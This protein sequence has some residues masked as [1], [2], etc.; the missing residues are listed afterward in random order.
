MEIREMPVAVEKRSRA[1]GV[2]P[3]R[4]RLDAGAWIEAAFEALARDGVEA[5]R[6]EP[7]A[8]VLGVTKGSFYWHFADRD[9]LIGALFE[10]W[11]EGR[12]AA[13][14]AETADGTDA[15]ATLYRL[16]DLYARGPNARGLAIELAIRG[17]ARG[18]ARAAAAVNAVDAE[19]L[20]RVA[21]LFNAL[22]SKPAEA[23]AR[24]FLFYAFVFGQSLIARRS[25]VALRTAAADLFLR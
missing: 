16:I 10:R 1:L 14:R 24:A 21:G 17:L 3:R 12:V 15:S 7:L 20:A 11:A 18:D 5:V 19:R 23:E 6:I 25:D 13:I 4:A 9:A 2:R 22:G 8:A